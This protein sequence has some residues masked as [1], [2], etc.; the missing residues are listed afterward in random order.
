MTPLIPLI[1]SLL[2]RAAGDDWFGQKQRWGMLFALPFGY[3]SYVLYDTWWIALIGYVISWMAY[4]TGHG[5][6]YKMVGYQDHNRPDPDKPRKQKLEYVVEPIFKLFA[7]SK[8]QSAYSWACMGLKGLLIGLPLG[9]YA[10]FLAILWP[11]AYW[12]GRRYEK[13][14]AVSEYLSGM[15]AGTVILLAIG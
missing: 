5:T 4:E 7:I 3:A 6:F 9:W 8:E 10:P 11:S 15:A 13:S 2:A 12:L 1:Q 14:G